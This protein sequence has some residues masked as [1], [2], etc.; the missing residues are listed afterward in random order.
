MSD[1][2]SDVN[3]GNEASGTGAKPKCCTQC[4]QPVKGHEGPTGRACKYR[5]D[6]TYE[7]HDESG[8]EEPSIDQSNILKQLVSQMAALNVNLDAMRIGQS[9]LL[10]TV[11]AM[12]TD[13][14]QPP[15]NPPVAH[16]DN[17]PASPALVE[18]KQ[19][20]L[21]FG[22]NITEKSSKSAING[23]FANLSDFLPAITQSVTEMETMVSTGGSICVRPR[24]PQRAIDSFHMW[25]T[26]WSNY[27]SLI[28][29][30][31]PTLY[32]KFAHYRSFIQSCDSKYVWHA[33][34][35]YDCRF[36]ARLANNKSWDFQKSDT[37]IYITTF[38]A[39]TVKR[40]LKQ[41]FRCKSLDH[42]I[43]E[44]PFPAPASL[45]EN[46][47]KTSY[48]NQTTRRDRWV[49]QGKEGCHNFQIGRCTDIN[50]RR[51]HVCKSCRGPEPFNKCSHC[52]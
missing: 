12:N 36:R 28:L 18:T 47:K 11:Q 4:K 24:R 34:Y 27:E 14:A 3:P 40:N 29:S 7:D 39:T 10:H 26:S 43:A 38:D 46:K 42:A 16:H 44:C 25:L 31:R 23:E 8:T 41:C 15:N 37:D 1:K 32:S 30:N 49:H 50:C 33:V 13:N 17:H 19:I 48:N 45:E 22:G 6:A 9:A 52:H 35:A 5:E 2:E 21:E 20:A 51:A